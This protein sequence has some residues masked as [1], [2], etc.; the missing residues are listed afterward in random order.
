MTIP[1]H[2]P[3]TSLDLL[4]HGPLRRV[5]A[6]LVLFSEIESTNT[7]LLDQAAALPDGA[8]A[9]AEIQLGGRGRL[10]RRWVAPRGSS[11]LCSLLLHEPARSG[12]AD[13]LPMLAGVAAAEA[14]EQSAGLNIALRWPNDITC[15]GRKLGGILI[16]SRLPAAG[17]TAHTSRRT[18]VIGIGLNVFQQAGHFPPNLRDKATSLEIES[19]HVVDRARVARTLLERLDQ[20]L[21]APSASAAD[22]LRTEWL[23]RCRE[24]GERVR[25]AHD[26]R[27]FAGTILDIDRDGDL[28]VQLDQGGIRRFQ[29]SNTSRAW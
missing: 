21:A 22:H 20:L 6:R 26:G 15:N 12:L 25:L 1:T 24:L 19:P 17:N 13:S 3:L 8:V 28:L 5:G 10:G 23:R 2:A 7:Y 14:L 11:V 18:L 27:E 4:P 16:E 29:G 9:L